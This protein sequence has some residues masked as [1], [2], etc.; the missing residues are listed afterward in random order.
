ME[1]I[2]RIGKLYVCM[3]WVERSII[4]RVEIQCFDRGR[5]RG[6][7]CDCGERQTSDIWNGQDGNVYNM[8]FI[9]EME[10]GLTKNFIVSFIF[11]FLRD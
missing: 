3:V 6:G 10:N 5:G 11:I 4:G 9:L 7:G 1:E 2:I 8:L